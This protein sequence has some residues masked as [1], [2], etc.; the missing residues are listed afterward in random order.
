MSLAYVDKCVPLAASRGR[1]IRSL[2]AGRE[3]VMSCLTWVLGPALDPAQQQR[4][5]CLLRMASLSFILSQCCS[6]S[7]PQQQTSLTMGWNLQTFF[8]VHRLP[9]AFGHS[10]R[11]L[12]NTTPPEANNC[13]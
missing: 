7:G 4:L 9:P 12:T 5:S 3:V 10:D 13:S 2:G 8:L 1:Q 11:K 6:A